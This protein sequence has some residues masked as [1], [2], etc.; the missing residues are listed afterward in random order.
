M[1]RKNEG[2]FPKPLF[3]W[4]S[5]FSLVTFM[6][7]IIGSHIVLQLVESLRMYTDDFF[8]V[9]TILFMIAVFYV[10]F[11]RKYLRRK[12]AAR[13]RKN[14]EYKLSNWETNLVDRF[15]Y[16]AKYDIN[17]ISYATLRLN[18]LISLI[19]G[20]PLIYSFVCMIVYSVAQN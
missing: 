11:S 4:K 8:I 16:N 19:I 7:F 18:I 2:A 9:C 12:W 13:L 15:Y 3:N 1:R 17:S 6:L 14:N 20:P 10:V 5:W